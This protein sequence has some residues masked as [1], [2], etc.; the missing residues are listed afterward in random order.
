ML[1]VVGNG[2]AVVDKDLLLGGELEGIK[3]NAVLFQQ[4]AEVDAAH[5]AP[6]G[7]GDGVLVKISGT[8]ADEASQL[9]IQC[10]G[11]SLH[12]IEGGSIVQQ[13]ALFSGDGVSLGHMVGHDLF[14]VLGGGIDVDFTDFCH[15]YAGSFSSCLCTADCRFGCFQARRFS[16]TLCSRVSTV[17]SIK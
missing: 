5:Q 3:V 17:L 1:G 4:V 7:L 8:L 10:V 2:A 14:N 13:G 9:V 15:N 6:V 12:R 16:N 11:A